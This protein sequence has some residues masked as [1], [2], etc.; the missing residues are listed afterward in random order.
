MSA[1]IDK[2]RDLDYLL[3]DAVENGAE[4]LSVSLS[5]RYLHQ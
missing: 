4:S 3:A 5:M 2:A 1:V